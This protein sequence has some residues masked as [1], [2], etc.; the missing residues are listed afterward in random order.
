MKVASTST[1]HGGPSIAQETL[2]SFMRPSIN[3]SAPRGPPIVRKHVAEIMT[4]SQ[5]EATIEAFL[6]PFEMA[7]NVVSGR[8]APDRRAED[9][10]RTSESSEVDAS[11]DNSSLKGKRGVHRE[12]SWSQTGQDSIDLEDDITEVGDFSS[13]FGPDSLMQHAPER[14]KSRF[15]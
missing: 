14:K 5:A 15:T 11:F 7:K 4:P 10:A 12:R 8:R 13:W 9:V 3:P 1:D 2:D 6:G